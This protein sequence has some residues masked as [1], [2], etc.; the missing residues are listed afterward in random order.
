MHPSQ[1]PCDCCGLPFED[2]AFCRWVGV[3]F[4]E[5]ATRMICHTC[6]CAMKFKKVQHENTE[7]GLAGTIDGDVVPLSDMTINGFDKKEAIASIKAVASFLKLS[8]NI[9]KQRL[10]S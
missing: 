9:I 7:I 2:K 8:K 5:K 4:S 3:P 1:E 6:I 10:N